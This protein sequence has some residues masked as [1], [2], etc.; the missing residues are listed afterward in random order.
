MM[1]MLAAAVAPNKQTNKQEED[2]SSSSSSS[3]RRLFVVARVFLCSSARKVIACVRVR[4]IFRVA[5]KH[6]AG[7]RNTKSAN[8]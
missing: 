2:R 3:A 1:W 7:A 5:A 6:L 8:N 4:V